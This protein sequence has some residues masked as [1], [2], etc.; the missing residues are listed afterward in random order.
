MSQVKAERQDRGDRRDRDR[1]G[2]NRDRRDRDRGRDR[3]GR[4]RH[5]DNEP[6]DRDKKRSYFEKP[7]DEVTSSKCFHFLAVSHFLNHSK[8]I[9]VFVLKE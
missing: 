8:V 9:L 2:D 7:A 4:D 3:G 6:S 5:P 1:V